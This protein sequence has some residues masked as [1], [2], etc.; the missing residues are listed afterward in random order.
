MEEKC[1]RET[2]MKTRMS[3]GIVDPCCLVVVVGIL[4]MM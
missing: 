4:T 2:G 1:L 3:V